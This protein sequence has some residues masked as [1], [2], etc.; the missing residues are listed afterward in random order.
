MRL[1]NET[2]ILDDLRERERPDIE[3]T[4]HLSDI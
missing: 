2:C 3:I 1:D 4:P